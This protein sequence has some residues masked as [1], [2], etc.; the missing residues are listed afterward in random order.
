MQNLGERRGVS[1]SGFLRSKAA[2]MTGNGHSRYNFRNQA[3]PLGI[4]LKAI[5]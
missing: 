1:K 4:R 3:K 2:V 5:V